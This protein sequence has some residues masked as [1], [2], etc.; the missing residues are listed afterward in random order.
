MAVCFFC[1]I[2]SQ[3]Y[4][5]IKC[6][7]P[8]QSSQL[9]ITKE[10]YFFENAKKSETTQKTLLFITNFAQSKFSNFLSK[11]DKTLRIPNFHLNFFQLFVFV[12]KLFEF[13]STVQQSL[14]KNS[15]DVSFLFFFVCV[16]ISYYFTVMSIRIFE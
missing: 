14:D 6:F 4:K 8:G 7:R 1:K 11:P 15:F 5:E 9:H 3:K 13:F 10:N 2:S 12:S 16:M